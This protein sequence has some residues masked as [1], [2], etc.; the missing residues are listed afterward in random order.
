MTMKAVRLIQPGRPLELEHIPIPDI[1]DGDLLVR[2]RAAGVCHSDAHY[3]AGL[4]VMGALPITLGHEIAGVV[5]TAGSRVTHFRA[6]DRVCLH[7]N[8]TCG[9]CHYC[10]TGSEQMCATARMLGHHIDGGYAEFVRVPARNAIALPVEIPFEAAATLM[11]AS[12]TALH[13]LIKGRVKAGDTVAIFGVGG[14]GLS[15][16]QLARAMGAV[17]VF[18]VD[19]HPE[20]LQLAAAY[21]AIPVDASRVDAAQ[22]LRRLTDGRGVS[23]ALEMVGLKKTLEQAIDCLGKLGRAVVVGVTQ[24]PIAINTYRQL[25]GKE[26]EIIGANDHLLSELPL[27]VDLVR[28][29]ILDTS[30]VV[31]QV[32]PLDAGVINRRLDALESYTSDVRAVITP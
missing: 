20:K 23:L 10:T 9:D 25:L 15:A 4:S 17:D 16:L 22:E 26:A 18:A 2:V 27:L 8:I 6:G 29:G 7:Y 13:A 12:A 31:S 19:I 32:I 1:G 28:R 21:H 30:R 3:R 5:E 24:E 11:C 14:L